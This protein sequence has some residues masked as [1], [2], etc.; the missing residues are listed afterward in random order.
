MEHLCAKHS[1]VAARGARSLT[2]LSPAMPLDRLPLLVISFAT[3]PV[4]NSSAAN[5]TTR[6]PVLTILTHPPPSGCREKPCSWP[7]V[8]QNARPS[9]IDSV[10]WSCRRCRQACACITTPSRPT[11]QRLTAVGWF[12]PWDSYMY[13]A[14]KHSTYET[15]CIT[16]C[17]R[18]RLEAG[19]LGE[20]RQAR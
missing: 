17:H 20:Q 9:L 3:S 8:A 11:V 12:W 5:R 19:S 13:A 18:S 2:N 4:H 6:W 1:L 16:S 7:P 10:G 15:V 14:R